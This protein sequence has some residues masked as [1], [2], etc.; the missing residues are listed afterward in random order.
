MVERRCAGTV[1][2]MR[3]PAAGV[4]SAG[5]EPLRSRENSEL[6][7][8]AGS[9]AMVDAAVVDRPKTK[10]KPNAWLDGLS[11]LGDR[12][13]LGS[14]VAGGEGV[15]DVLRA[16]VPGASTKRVSIAMSVGAWLK[17][18]ARGGLRVLSDN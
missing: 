15:P 18:I 7:W 3:S 5:T 13:E 10:R 8:R 11:R 1:S 16:E 4:P 2:V 6:D 17:D 12:D 14:D 9:S